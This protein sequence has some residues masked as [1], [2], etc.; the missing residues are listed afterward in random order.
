M[1]RPRGTESTHWGKKQSQSDKHAHGEPGVRLDYHYPPDFMLKLEGSIA[2]CRKQEKC[3]ALLLVMIDNL[4]MILEA[5]GHQMTEEIASSL[6]G[7]IA[8]LV[9][10]DGSSIHRIQRDQFAVI[11]PNCTQ[12][13]IPSLAS[14]INHLAQNYGVTASVPV[15]I[16]TSVGS[17]DFPLSAGTAIE[18]VDKAYVALRNKTGLNCYSGYEG[19]E[20]TQQTSIKQMELAQYLTTAI[21]TNRLRLAYQPVINAKTGAVAHY[22]CLLRLVDQNGKINS[23]GVLIPIAEKMGMI[24]IIDHLVLEMVF[25]E[26]AQAPDVVLAYNI[27]NMTT[28]DRKWYGRFTEIA[29]RHPDIASRMVIEITETAAHR[30]LRETAYF[31]ASLQEYG[32]RVALDD[33]GSGYTSFRQLKALSVDMIKID[34]SFVKDLVDNVDNRFFVKTLLDFTNA[35]GLDSVAECVETGE[36]AKLLMEL[37]VQFMQGYYFAKALNYRDWLNDGEYK[38]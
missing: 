2:T 32:A 16:I 10:S 38:A 22:E 8:N 36:T 21:Q 25:K 3:G 11:V 31:V 12:D 23:A 27:S 20:N 28:S 18:A 15:H 7:S 24:N 19:S 9:D 4:S 26:L 30:D 6:C 13:Y 14:Q 1:A 34:G 5:H 37:G 35:F 17:V 29:T 33:F